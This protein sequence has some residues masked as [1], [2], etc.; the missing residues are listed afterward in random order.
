MAAQLE[1]LI[2]KGHFGDGGRLP[3]ERKLA[4]QFGVGRGTMRE[5]VSKL[6]TLGILVK[7]QGVGTF[8]VYPPPQAAGRMLMLTA[9][10][11]T[12]LELFEVRYALEP[13]AAATAAAR[14]TKAD[15]TEL[16]GILKRSMAAAIE[17]AEFVSLDFQFHNRI[18]QASNNRLMR[19]LYEQIGPHHAVYSE[20]VIAIPGRIER[21]CEGHQ[22]ILNAIAQ[23]DAEGARSAALDH[24]RSAERDLALEAS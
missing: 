1:E 7:N 17:G 3:A 12:A 24:L 22:R 8:A 11:V 9:G 13:E 4:E 21:A 14:R 2:Q 6:E 5:A 15:L 23:G 20:K 19:R 18:I 10:D 16:R